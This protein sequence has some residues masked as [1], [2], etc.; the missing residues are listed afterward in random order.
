MTGIGIVSS[1]GLSL[2]KFWGNMVNGKS[3]IK[4]ISGF[5]AK[6]LPI[7]IA[8]E[9]DAQ[10][11]C[12]AEKEIGL[13]PDDTIPKGIRFALLATK[14]ALLDAGLDGSAADCNMGLYLGSHILPNIL[15]QNLHVFFDNRKDLYSD[16]FKF[17]FLKQMNQC[18]SFNVGLNIAKNFH[19][20][21]SINLIHASCASSAQAIGEAFHLIK[22]GQKDIMLCGGVDS[23]ITFEGISFFNSLG[24]LSKNPNPQLASR[25]FDKNRNG[26]V[27]GEG[28]G[29]VVLESAESARKRGAKIWCEVKGYANMSEAYHITSPDPAGYV[30]AASI[31]AALQEAMLDVSQID[32]I[33]AHGTSTVVNDRMETSVI[34]QTFG[35]RAYR[36]PITANKSMIGHTVTAAGAIELISTIQS[37]VYNVIPPTVN[38]EHKDPDCDLDYVPNSARTQKVDNAIS[39]TFAFGGQDVCLV[40]G[41]S[42]L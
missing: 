25:P 12:F 34:K 31:K 2:S 20:T 17:H 30:Q 10:S 18:D 21:E 14:M 42:S 3:G 6:H 22:H 24:V 23:L 41:K 7:Q 1:L 11:L 28:A 5:D 8:G 27:L 38:Y 26:F 13:D 33:N 37:V 39:N 9:I 19:L 35:Q 40:V 29:L 15:S 36:I 16:E 32:L 4:K